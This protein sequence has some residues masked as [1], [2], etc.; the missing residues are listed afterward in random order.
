[1]PCKIEIKKNIT[2]D[3]IERSNDALSMSLKDANQVA[4]TINTSYGGVRVIS[5]GM[6]GED[7]ISRNINIPPTLVDAY[8]DNELRLETEHQKAI[9]QSVVDLQTSEIERGEYTEEHRGEFYQLSESPM[10][11]ASPETINKVKEAAKKMGIDIQDLAEYAKK[12]GLDTKS[13]NGVADLVK[14]IVALAQGHEDVALT[15]EMVH[16]ATAILEQTNPSFITQLISKIDRFKIYDLTYKAYKDNKN[17]QLSNGKPDIRKIKKEAVD[18]LIA[19]LIINQNEGTT[20]YPELRDEKDRSIIKQWWNTILDYIRGVYRKTNIDLFEDVA[21]QVISGNVGDYYDSILNATSTDIDNNVAN[22]GAIIIEGT[23]EDYD[24][25]TIISDD[26]GTYAEEIYYKIKP[27]AVVY[28]RIAFTS[29]KEAEKAKNKWNLKGFTGEGVFYQLKNDKVDALYN[30]IIDMDSRLELN[31]ETP[32]DKRHYTFDGEKVASS[33]TEKVKGSSKMPERSPTDKIKDEV[34]RDWGSNGHAFIEQYITN[35]LIDKDGYKR[36]VPIDMTIDSAISPKIQEKLKAFAIELI[37]SYKEGTRFII[38]RKVVNDKVKGKLASTV[39]FIAIE[40]DE[41]TGVK[42]DILDWKFTSI[43]KTKDD[44]IP[45]F[46]QGEWK[47]QMGEYTK[48]MYNYG[49]KPDQLRKARMIPFLVNYENIVAGDSKSGIMAKSLEIGKLNSLTETN[50]YLLPVPLNSETTG[51]SRVD[52]L[53]KALRTQHEKLWKTP[54]SPEARFAKIIQVNQLSAA[55]RFLHLKLDFEPLVNV[56]KSFLNNAAKSFKEFENLDYS[57]LTK[58]EVQKKL[59]DLL[60]Y[61]NS[62]EKFALLDE[63][64]LSIF[65]KEGLDAAAKVT[66]VNLEQISSATGRMLNKIEALQKEYVVQL[67]LK[68]E[69]TTEQTKLTVLDAEVAINGFAKTFLEGSKLSAKLINLASNLLMNAKNIVNRKIVSSIKEYEKVLLPLEKEAR[70]RGKRAFDMI[71]VVS[72]GSLHLIKKIDKAFWNQI[73]EAKTAKNKQFFLDNMNLTEYNALVKDAL[74]KGEEELKNIQ[75]STDEKT[76][77][78]TRS[79][80]IKKLRDSLDIN[81][82]TFNGYEGYQF[83][84]IFNQVMKEEGH[85]SAEYQEMSKSEAALNVWNFFTVLNRRAKDLGYIEKQGSSFFPLVEATILEKFFQ[86]SDVLSQTKDFFS[87]FYTTRIDEEQGFSKIDTETGLIKKQIPKYFTRTN[88]SV[89]QLSVDLNKVGSIWIKSLLEYENSKNME[90]TLLTMHSVEQAKGSLIVDDN[91]YV[92]FE[93]GKPKINERENKNAQVLETIIN[94]SVYRMNQ[95]LS[96]IGNIS[97]SNLASKMKSDEEEREKTTLSIKKGMK[98]ADTLVRA[99][100]VGLKPLIGLANWAGFQ[101]QAFIASGNMYNFSEF[102]KNNV[103]TSTGT[104]SIIERALLDMIVPLNDDITLETRRQLAKKQ[105]YLEYLSTWSFTDVMMVT[106][107]F[108]ERKLQLANALSFNDNSMV[109]DGK[110]VNIRQYIKKQDSHRYKTMAYAERRELEKTFEARVTELK[111]S[112]SLTNVAKIEN[113]DVIIPGVTEEALAKYRTKVVE[114]ART[115]NGQMNED[116]KAGYRRDSIFSSFM[117]FKTWIPKLVS[118]RILDI[119]KNTELDE[120]E[121]GRVRV[122]VKTWTHLGM[123]NIGN[124]R[125]IINGTDAGIKILDEMLEAKR[126][127]YFKKTGQILEITEEEFYD[128]IRTELQREMKELSLLLGVMGLVLAA[129]AAEP[130]EDAT[131]LEKNRYK[132][133]AKAINKISDEIAFYYNPTSAESISKGSII[134]AL[135]LLSKVERIII[136][137][138]KEAYGQITNDEAMVKKAYPVK[139]F[140]NIIPGAA[141]FQTE[142]LPYINPELAKSMGIKVTTQARRQ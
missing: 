76:N 56:G 137:I 32:T 106:N 20:E 64:F 10:S 27:G 132:F 83:G 38:E 73:T 91:G 23:K 87:D 61:K 40:P 11:K 135:G 133:W 136:S 116:N 2:S 80:R 65:P 115:L 54:V 45:W 97:I 110:I 79:Y 139:Y 102:E 60:E 100:A 69:F 41:K 109:V 129:K 33:V 5:F 8:Y 58:E 124:M 22:S 51:N 57:K 24:G 101:M 63:I 85:Y 75:F 90:N 9:D 122:F 36:D 138:S 81:R 53:I 82:D 59:G 117:M 49:L 47:L 95:D 142:I 131:D 112:S 88:K 43:D 120:W 3:V 128:L 118:V 74:T 67:A 37:N 105:G 66:L 70:S 15:E 17:Y 55:I 72:N 42:I 44:D 98:N 28:N 96:S 108:P 99:L 71:G 123:K 119:K 52:D 34:K 92:I 14:G 30:T 121:Y 1:M 35:C 6:E 127:E 29:Y 113:D 68:E 31:P 93:G 19:E 130:P 26:E 140:L 125:D 62:A 134:P 39:D 126:I 84:Y 78:T 111:N 12:R 94:D 114:Y 141:Q 46:K 16:I 4:T 21:K 89:E 18:K 86:T 103:K 25:I 107:S 104:I 50:L 13:I 77:D 7:V 48:I